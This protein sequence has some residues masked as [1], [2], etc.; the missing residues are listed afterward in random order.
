MGANI[1]YAMQGSGSASIAG[2]TSTQTTTT[3]TGVGFDLGAKAK[4]DAIPMMPLAVALVLKDL[5]STLSGITSAQT[6]RLAPGL[7]FAR[8]RGSEAA[9]VVVLR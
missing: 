5:G 3:L 7:Y 9:R 8:P 6:Q 4:V 2:T 1:K